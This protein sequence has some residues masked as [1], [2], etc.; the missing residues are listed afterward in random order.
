MLLAKAKAIIAGQTGTGIITTVHVA[1][2]AALDP[3][4]RMKAD[5]YR[6]ELTQALQAPWSQPIAAVA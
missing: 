4:F 3:D 2:S 5:S 6:R 1:G